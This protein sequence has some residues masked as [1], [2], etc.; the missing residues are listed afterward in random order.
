MSAG[1]SISMID[2]SK[3]SMGIGNYKGVMLCNRPFGGTSG[4]LKQNG[5]SESNAFSC[6]VISDAIGVNVTISSKDKH[7]I[8]RPKKD[9]VISKHRKWLADLQKQKDM[10]ETQYINEMSDKKDAQ[11]KFTENEA[12]LR[13]AAKTISS[14]ETS[15]DK[16]LL[17]AELLSAFDASNAQHKAES[18]VPAAVLQESKSLGLESK[19]P[20]L[21]SV[22]AQAKTSGPNVGSSSSRPAW[23]LSEIAAAAANEEKLLG[24]EDELLSFAEGL[25]FDRYIGDMEVRTVMDR[26]RQRISEME[27]EVSMEEKREGASEERAAKK[28]LLAQMIDDALHLGQQEEKS[29]MERDREDARSVLNSEAGADLQNI[30]SNKSVVAMIKTSRDKML[31]TV[32]QEPKVV[33]HSDD[34]G[35]RLAKLKEVANL[36]YMHRN[37]AV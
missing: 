35:A 22:H 36:P 23:A 16:S 20:G 7:K 19:I 21:S 2:N 29:E 34:E 28:D 5:A 4:A 14:D 6:G 1:P 27:R 8:E 32:I 17:T 18:K 37:P 31:G 25:D 33:T 10:L 12:K 11:M 13:R 3:S 30:H 9:S 26:L 15:G 24:D